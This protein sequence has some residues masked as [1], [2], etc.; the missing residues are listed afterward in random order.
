MSAYDNSV[1]AVIFKHEDSVGRLPIGP[2]HIRRNGVWK[3][4]KNSDRLDWEG[5]PTPA[6]FTLSHAKKVARGLNL[7][8]FEV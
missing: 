3:P 6:W 5:K 1:D 8:L 4:F 2:I 7:P